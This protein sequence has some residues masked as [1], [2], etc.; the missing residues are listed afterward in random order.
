MQRKFKIKIKLK[1]RDNPV[2]FLTDKTSSFPEQNKKT[3]SPPMD[4]ILTLSKL[5]SMSFCL[6]LE[7]C[8][9]FKI[10]VIAPMLTQSTYSFSEYYFLTISGSFLLPTYAPSVFP[11]L[12]TIILAYETSLE[13]FFNPSI[14]ATPT[15]SFLPLT[16]SN[17][18]FFLS[19]L[20]QQA[21]KFTLSSYAF[22]R[23]TSYKSPLPISICLLSISLSLP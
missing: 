7:T 13:E 2:P 18:N 16:T 4:I 21:F 8:S 12:P 20:L 9:P 14:C 10:L 22:L 5:A 19:A 11:P 15:S 1:G 3:L 17:H 23:L 6:T